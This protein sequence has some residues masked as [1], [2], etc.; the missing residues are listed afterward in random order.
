ML[1]HP[2]SAH[3]PPKDQRE[4]QRFPNLAHIPVEHLLHKIHS[5]CSGDKKKQTNYVSHILSKE[6]AIV[7]V[8]IKNFVHGYS[9]GVP[10]VYTV[11]C[12]YLQLVLWEMVAHVQQLSSFLL[13][14]ALERPC[15]RSL[16]NVSLYVARCTATTL[17]N[18]N[19]F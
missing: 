12:P 8:H 11:R 1:E 4:G 6:G 14:L 13:C 19:A 16:L 7:F 15:C 18:L 3:L 17:P 10:E 5:T 9:H 2:K